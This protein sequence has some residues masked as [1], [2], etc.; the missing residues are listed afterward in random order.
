MF[1]HQPSNI[2][3]S[4]HHPH[5]LDPEMWGEWPHG[6]EFRWDTKSPNFLLTFQAFHGFTQWG[7]G[8]RVSK[9]GDPPTSFN[10]RWCGKKHA[11]KDIIRRPN[12]APRISTGDCYTKPTSSMAKVVDSP[13][14]DL[15]LPIT[16]VTFCGVKFLWL[17]SY[18]PNI[19]Q[20]NPKKCN[21][22]S[23]SLKSS[24]STFGSKTLCSSNYLEKIAL[25]H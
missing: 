25:C 7:S 4:C 11:M 18:R 8:F 16:S 14:V 12:L 15:S 9:L 23:K 2:N 1:G 13:Q 5:P 24:F 10:W 22:K 6:I 19:S 21:P 17:I 20:I 3:S